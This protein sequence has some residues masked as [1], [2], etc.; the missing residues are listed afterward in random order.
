MKVRSI[1]CITWDM[2]DER[3][4]TCW[5]IRHCKICATKINDG[6]SLSPEMCAYECKY[7]CLETERQ[8]KQMIAIREFKNK[9]YRKERCE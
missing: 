1:F 2:F 7:D 5:N 6:K 9:I 4:A 8:I 3:C